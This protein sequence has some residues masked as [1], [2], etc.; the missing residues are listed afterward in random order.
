MSKRFLICCLFASDANAHGGEGVIFFGVIFLTFYIYMLIEIVRSKLR[1]G[2]K[3]CF[4]LAILGL[5][6]IAVSLLEMLGPNAHVWDV[7]LFSAIALSLWLSFW[8][9]SRPDSK[10]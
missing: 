9:L 5:N 4:L 10:S 3:V 7:P 8:F 6:G 1:V 2:M